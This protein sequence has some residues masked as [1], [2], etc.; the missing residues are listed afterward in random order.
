VK[1]KRAGRVMTAAF[2]AMQFGI[3]DQNDRKSSSSR[4][5]PGPIATDLEFVEGWSASRAT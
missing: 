3:F 1:V 5:E 2:D 4:P